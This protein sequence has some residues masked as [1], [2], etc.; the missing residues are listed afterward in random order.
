M[1]VCHETLSYTLLTQQRGG[2]L[3]SGERAMHGVWE[4]PQ[5]EVACLLPVFLLYLSCCLTS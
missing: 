1:F 5:L 3:L 2:S 4:E